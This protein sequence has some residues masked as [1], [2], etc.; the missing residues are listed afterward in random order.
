MS[1]KTLMGLLF[2]TLLPIVAV[3]GDYEQ[4]NKHNSQRGLYQQHRRSPSY[5]YRGHAQQNYQRSL[6]RYQNNPTSH[7]YQVMH[8]RKQIYE[9]RNEEYRKKNW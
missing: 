3:A 9:M 1:L 5:D 4:Q 6:D 7:N 8:Q 2:V